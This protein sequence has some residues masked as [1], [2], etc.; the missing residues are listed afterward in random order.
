MHALPAK[1]YLPLS[2]PPSLSRPACACASVRATNKKPLKHHNWHADAIERRV[3]RFAHQELTVL[4]S[5]GHRL[6]LAA[7]Y[8]CL[9][10]ILL[11]VASLGALKENPID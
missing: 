4:L 6:G 10:A 1:T 11:I 8:A 3:R 2:L 7:T 9:W 5:V